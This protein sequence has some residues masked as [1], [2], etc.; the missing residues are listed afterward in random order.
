MF[1]TK[2]EQPNKLD[3]LLLLQL[4]C[5]KKLRFCNMFFGNLEFEKNGEPKKFFFYLSVHKMSSVE[6]WQGD[7]SCYLART[8]IG[9]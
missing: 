7:P 8:Y 3:I 4:I 6:K 1:V 9:R 2:K 5:S